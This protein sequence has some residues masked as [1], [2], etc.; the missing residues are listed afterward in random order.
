MRRSGAFKRLGTSKHVCL[1]VFALV[2]C[3]MLFEPLL[4]YVLHMFTWDTGVKYGTIRA[5]SAKF[6]YS[7]NWVT[8]MHV[9][10]YD[11]III[12]IKWTNPKLEFWTVEAYE[13][14]RNVLSKFKTDVV[15]YPCE[16]TVKLCLWNRPLDAE[17][18]CVNKMR[19]S[20]GQQGP[21]SI[22]RP[23]LCVWIPII[24]DKKIVGRS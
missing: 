19:H 4:F 12:H 24:K 13:W 16:I 17:G 9:S 7:V 14:K 23:P 22:A 3:V 2:F 10:R 1:S 18:C 20:P 8:K 6:I 5:A 21:V 11:F 15:S